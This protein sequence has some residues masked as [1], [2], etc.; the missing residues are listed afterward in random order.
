MAETS[1]RVDLPLALR[2]NLPALIGA[3]LPMAVVYLLLSAGESLGLVLLLPLGCLALVLA[4]RWPDLGLAMLAVLVAA[5]VSQNLT[6]RYGLQSTTEILVA[7]L[8]LVV[9]AR[10]V[11]LGARPFV[12]PLVLAVL[13]LWLAYVSAGVLRADHWTVSR[14]ASFL[15]AKTFVLVV[16]TLA[17]VDS[18]ARLR[19]YLKALI[20]TYVT[21][22]LLGIYLYATGAPGSFAGFANIEF[23]ERRFTGPYPDANFF[24]S[25]LA[26]VLP[27]AVG[28]ALYGADRGK[29]LLGFAAAVV[30][31]AGLLLTASRGGLLAVLLT[32]PLFL[33]H[34][35]GRQRFRAIT[36]GLVL[37]MA[38]SF[39]LSDQLARRFGFLVSPGAAAPSVDVSVEGRLASWAVAEKLFLDHPWFG[40]GIGNFNPHFQD[41]ALK[42]G[43]IFRGEARS[44]H[45]LY[46]EA[47]AEE[48]LVGLVLLLAILGL[49]ARTPFRV[50]RDCEARGEKDLAQDLRGLGIGLLSMLI[51]RLFLHDDFPILMWTVLALALACEA[52][53]QPLPRPASTLS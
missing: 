52:I 51:A 48:G 26:L 34:M 38:T 15:L 22:C 10:R 37:A 29:R 11:F 30:L 18:P 35:E 41:T 17:L 31:M 27:M 23:A 40:V 8:A 21:I 32:A 39:A 33:I 5:E 3:A 4:F 13:G 7:G 12:S 49:A 28:K 14:E 42:L 45:G 50:A 16:A 43:L 25:F 36:L 20:G 9:L 53:V 2:R 47:A 19:L 6:A 24:A 44:A 1:L 46:H